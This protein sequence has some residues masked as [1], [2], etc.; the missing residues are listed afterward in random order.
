MEM[1]LQLYL[2]ILKRRALIIAIVAA[3]AM[4]VVAA[5]G[6]LKPPIY[7]A[8]TTVRVLLEVGITDFRVPESHN[9]R[10]LN[11]C[12]HILKSRSALDEAISRLSPRTSSLTVGGLSQNV[13]SEIVKD[14]DLI[15]IAVRNRDPALAR[16]LANTLATLLTEYAQHLYVGSS[17]VARE[18]VEEQLASIEKQ[19]ESDYQQLDILLASGAPAGQAEALRSKI[20]SEE[21]AHDRLSDRY[22]L[23]R[24][25]EAL[26]ANSITI[27]TPASLPTVPSNTLG[28]KQIGLSLLVGLFGGVGLALVLENLD[29]RI[30]SSHQLERQT[31]LPVLGVV[32]QGVLSLNGSPHANGTYN[33]KSIEEAYRLLSINLQAL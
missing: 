20:R 17:M 21:D 26:R 23:A 8:R 29:T 2:D 33:A 18:V 31:N 22:E 16:D 1:E 28:L 30:H 11:T 19:L 27:V 9:E 14:T 6:I 7:T 4:S 25:N 13:S 5:V 32:P 3:L 10:L 24:M 12:R 15:S